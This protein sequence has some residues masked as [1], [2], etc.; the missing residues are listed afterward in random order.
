MTRRTERLLLCPLLVA[1]HQQQAALAYN[2][3]IVP[4]NLASEAFFGLARR[5]CEEA[6]AAIP[7]FG[8]SYNGTLEADVEGT[9]AILEALVDDDSVG[10][11]AVS[12][13]DPEAYTPVINRGIA[14]GKPILT[15]DS[16]APNSDRLAYI[17]TDNYEMGRELAKLLQQIQPMGGKYGMLSGIGENLAERVRGVRDALDETDWVIVDEVPKNGQESID[18]SLLKLR[19]LV[20]EYP[21]INA[22]VS[23]V[24]T[25]SQKCSG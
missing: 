1:L 9:I 24:G 8:C 19:E 13:L 12:V 25:V 7:N 6:T 2:I 21:E 22:I 5:G 4:K 18:I 17:G 14:E 10:A 3:A 20:E 16:D 23:V 15:F 11:I